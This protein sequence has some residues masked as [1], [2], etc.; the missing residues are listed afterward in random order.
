MM[1]RKKRKQTPEER[2][3]LARL[4]AHYAETTRLLE[5][6]IAYH[7]EKLREEHGG[8]EPPTWQE[9]VLSLAQRRDGETV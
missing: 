6:R 7:R 9:Y 3:E 2:A 4:K 8:T 1:K 5:E